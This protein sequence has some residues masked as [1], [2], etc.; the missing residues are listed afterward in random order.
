MRDFTSREIKTS[1]A[2]ACSP[3]EIVISS[4]QSQPSELKGALL[5]GRSRRQDAGARVRARHDAA[6]LG[7]LVRLR[8]RRQSQ[9]ATTRRRPRRRSPSRRP[10][11]S[12]SPMSCSSRRSAAT[13]RA[14]TTNGA[15]RLRRHLETPRRA[16]AEREHRSRPSGFKGGA[17]GTAGPVEADSTQQI[18]AQ[19]K[20]LADCR[21]YSVRSG[22]EAEEGSN[23]KG[24][25][26]EGAQWRDN[27]VKALC[28]W[29]DS[30]SD[31]DKT[32]GRAGR[33]LRRRGHPFDVG[34]PAP[35]VRRCRQVRRRV[36]E[37]GPVVLRLRALLPRRPQVG[38]ATWAP[39]R[40]RTTRTASATS[41]TTTTSVARCRAPDW[42]RSDAPPS[43]AT[44]N[45]A[46]KR[47]AEPARDR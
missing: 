19:Q 10:G 42:P 36:Q 38:R 32:A 26:G 40:T 1:T 45:A 7:R 11:P 13:A 21:T 16:R 39:S 35:D 34:E 41:S 20:K 27:I 8:R 14:S 22:D 15:A 23:L 18:A 2:T 17:G 33:P 47:G 3:T 9:P 29:Y 37:P 25:L 43:T 44:R 28:D 24:P 46:R 6:R 30:S 4:Y 5:V 31:D 12:S